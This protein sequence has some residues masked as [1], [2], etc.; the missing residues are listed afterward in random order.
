MKKKI[1][2]WDS[3]DLSCR[4]WMESDREIRAVFMKRSYIL[5]GLIELWGA[6]WRRGYIFD[7]SDQDEPKDGM[8]R[9]DTSIL[10]INYTPYTCEYHY[11]NF[12]LKKRIHEIANEIFNEEVSRF[13]IK[14]QNKKQ[15]EAL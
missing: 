12:D 6:I 11:R 13:K 9:L 4:V 2:T 7:V 14:R 8:P 5:F 1:I 15:I 10:Y 3:H